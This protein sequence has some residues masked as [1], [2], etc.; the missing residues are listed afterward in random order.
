MIIDG[1]TPARVA[2]GE[3]FTILG[4]N[5][6]REPGTRIP[7]VNR[8]QA[9]LLEVVHWSDEAITVRVP[10]EVPYWG[11]HKVLIYYD[12][13][14]R[15]SSN[16][17]DFWVTA[18]P[19]PETVVDRWEVQ[20]RSFAAKYGK[21]DEWVTW[22]IDNRHLWEPTFLKAYEAPCTLTLA[23]SYQE[24]PP[25][26]DP[27]WANEDE[28]MAAF[29]RMA[30]AFFPSFRFRM[31]FDGD[32]ADTY[33]QIIII[34]E[35]ASYGGSS[36]VGIYYEGIFG[37]E[38]AHAMGLNHHYA[39]EDDHGGM[40]NMP[41]GDT[42]CTMDR[43]PPGFCSG[44]RTA[45]NIPLDLDTSAAEAAAIREIHRRYPPGY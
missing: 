27:P 40:M 26:Y 24:A 34:P 42:R 28:H 2:P 12:A 8:C 19:V 45:L 25:A 20:V 21:N 38:W 17:I 1:V 18:A 5:F 41:P 43:T 33:G 7:S 10:E 14:F 36:V 31:V 23:Y 16:S 11:Q 30:E 32:P 6:G 3:T 44:G 22:M 4:R 29:A 39:T 15:T 35:N 37:H 13:S 9:N